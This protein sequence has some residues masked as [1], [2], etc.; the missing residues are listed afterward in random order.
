MAKSKQK[1]HGFERELVGTLRALGY[2]AERAWGSNGKALGEA[3][4]V[5]V[6]FAGLGLPRKRVQAKR[7]AK[8]ASYMKPSDT[9]DMVM[10][11]EDRGETLV[12]MRLEDMLDMLFEARS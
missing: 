1:G 3:E 9:V 4:D 6:V 5:D 8:L 11:R 10:M 2:E 12:V 7:R